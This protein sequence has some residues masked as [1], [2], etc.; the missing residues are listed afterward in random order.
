MLLCYSHKLSQEYYKAIIPRIIAI[1]RPGNALS[2]GIHVRAAAYS[3]SCMLSGGSQFR[4]Q[5]LAAGIALPLLQATFLDLQIQIQIQPSSDKASTT[6][7]A[8]LLPEDSLAA[9]IKI[10][11]NTDP[12]PNLISMLLSP[13][14]PA[15]YSLAACMSSKKTKDPALQESID[16]IIST[17]GRIVDAAEGIQVVWRVVGGEGGDWEVD[18]AG[19]IKRSER[20][21]SCPMLYVLHLILGKTGAITAFDVHPCQP[22]GSR[23]GWGARH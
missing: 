22:P 23:S 12:S 21:V 10:L 8:A 19:Q 20:Q 7:N 5:E 13:I 17:W 4:Y 14:L 3:L 6:E 2:R 18:V 1:L 15:L 9:L 16:G 11:T